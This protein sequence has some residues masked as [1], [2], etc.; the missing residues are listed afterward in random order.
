MPVRAAGGPLP[1]HRACFQ[2]VWEVEAQDQTVNNGGEATEQKDAI[3]QMAPP[4]PTL[5]T[6]NKKTDKEKLCKKK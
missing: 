5:K 3:P 6:R 2:L 4:L 1:L